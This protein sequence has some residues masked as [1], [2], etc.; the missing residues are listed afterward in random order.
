MHAYPQELRD[1]VIDAWLRDEP[2]T[3]IA[4]RL[5]VSRSWAHKVIRRFQEDGNRCS[6]QMGGH[7]R[8]RVADM[9]QE[10]SEWIRAVP[11]LTLAQM[12]ERLAMQGVQLTPPAL[13]QQLK[14]WGFRYKKKL[15]TLPN[16]AALTFRKHVGS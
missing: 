14:K 1:R 12:C 15:F 9:Q 13:Y 7:R 4:C 3:D 5:E 6:A 8:S 16:K 11:N 2:V 10:I